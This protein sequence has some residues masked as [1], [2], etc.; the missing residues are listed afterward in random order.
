M[1]QCEVKAIAKSVSYI[2]KTKSNKIHEINAANAFSRQSSVFDDEY[3]EN[4]IVA[5]KRARV[6]AVLEK[7]LSVN[8][9][10]LELNSGT[11]DDAI[12]LAQQGHFVHAT[13]ISDGM[14]DM[15]KQK[16]ESAG[17]SNKITTEICSFNNLDTLA[18]KQLYDCIFS[19][20]AGLNCAEN[21]SKVLT[22]FSGLVK[23]NGIVTLVIMPKFSLWE[24]LLA[25][26]GEFK[27]AFRRL[28]STK[29]LGAKAHIMGQ[30]FRCWYYNPSY[31]I[32]CLKKDFSLLQLEGMCTIVPPSFI[33]SFP[34]KFPKCFR[35]FVKTEQRLKSIWP[36]TL[37][38]DYYIITLKKL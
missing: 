34:I 15:L 17:L 19:N 2:M 21:L 16:V 26:K 20:F 32:N 1:E 18:N 36:F 35:F 25:F 3:A 27:V 29:K 30:H 28:T 31:V 14:Q 8:S 11:G 13:D 22:H 23:Q 4:K 5:Y 9:S 10:I 24:F 33:E 37:I 38:G 6:R 7:Y 12:W